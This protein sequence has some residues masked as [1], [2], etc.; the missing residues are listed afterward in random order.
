M[1]ETMNYSISMR[2][3]NQCLTFS[4]VRLLSNLEWRS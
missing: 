2:K 4:V 1:R 3:L